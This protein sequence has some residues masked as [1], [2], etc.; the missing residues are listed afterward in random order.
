M[1]GN[2]A[3]YSV[4]VLIDYLTLGIT[5]KMSLPPVFKPAV[6]SG[7]FLY[8][9][10]L[11]DARGTPLHLLFGIHERKVICKKC[12][13]QIELT[14]AR[15]PQSGDGVHPIPLCSGWGQIIFWSTK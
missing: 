3:L 7:Q 6:N 10:I 4:R 5:P 8:A 1:I 13:L 2:G 11:S 14:Q 15:I 9:P 12:R